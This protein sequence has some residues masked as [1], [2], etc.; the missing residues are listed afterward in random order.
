MDL[1]FLIMAPNGLYLLFP[2]ADVPQGDENPGR[3]GRIITMLE[4]AGQAGVVVTPFFYSI[5]PGTV[6][7]K[8][9]IAAA[10]FFCRGCR[11][12]IDTAFYC[13]GCAVDRTPV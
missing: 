5:G 7:E 4:R 8:A 3:T 11:S 6:I 2:P 9:L 12:F 13:S 1:P 10:V